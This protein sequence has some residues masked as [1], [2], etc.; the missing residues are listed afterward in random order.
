MC[1]RK[2]ELRPVYYERRF[3]VRLV[4][5]RTAAT[6]ITFRRSY[7]DDR[8][9]GVRTTIT[10]SCSAV[11]RHIAYCMQVK[12]VRIMSDRSNLTVQ[13][14]QLPL[15]EVQAVLGWMQMDDRAIGSRPCEDPL[16][17]LHFSVILSKLERDRES[18]CGLHC[19]VVGCSVR[20]GSLDY[21][22]H[23]KVD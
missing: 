7:G 16:Y 11:T 2:T 12:H 19:S 18:S 21:C 22:H 20:F 10:S 9:L 23:R 13:S 14:V 5:T 4:V 1:T 6:V 15:A 3:C 8:P 17:D